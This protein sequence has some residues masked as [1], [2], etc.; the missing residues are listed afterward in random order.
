MAVNS[1]NK[2]AKKLFGEEVTISHG[3][4]PHAP[5]TTSPMLSELPTAHWRVKLLAP[6]TRISAELLDLL[7]ITEDFTT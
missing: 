3:W 7:G 4:I 5:S 6:I 1:M 2:L